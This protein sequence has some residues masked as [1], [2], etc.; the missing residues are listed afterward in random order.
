MEQ[1]EN[2][3]THFF[4]TERKMLFHQ[5]SSGC[6]DGLSDQYEKKFN[7]SFLPIYEKL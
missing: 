2:V 7:L 6:Q 4:S 1:E 3:L 5:N